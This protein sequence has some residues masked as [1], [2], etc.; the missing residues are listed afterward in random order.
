MTSDTPKQVERLTDSDIQMSYRLFLDRQPSETELTRMKA[1][2]SSIESLRK[3]FLTSSEF[4]HHYAPYAPKQKT[5]PGVHGDAQRTA[6][7]RAPTPKKLMPKLRPADMDRV[8]FLHVPKC[9][10]TSLHDILGDWYGPQNVHPERFNELYSYTGAQLATAQVFSGH[11]D[12]YATTLIPGS[13]KMISF[14]RDP[15]AR[16][17][18][19]YNFH[20]AHTPQIIARNNLLL[21]RWANELDIDDYFAEDKIRTHPAINNMIVRAF[22]NIPQTSPSIIGPK[23]TEVSLDVMLEQALENLEKFA[24]V[25]FMDTYD[26]DVNRLAQVLG[27][28]PLTDTP[29]Q[30][31][32][33]T[34]MDAG[35]NDMQK[36]QKQQ[37]SAECRDRIEEIIQYD[38]IFYTRARALLA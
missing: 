28:P 32:L 13:K 21:P 12:Y 1:A 9:G 22:S 16:L 19:L 35:D 36:I 30:Q 7:E 33:D 23:L 37:P 2:H 38:R 15:S 5:A 34:L 3:V 27:F 17:V 31:V 10:G 24:F 6:I 29:K 25:G 14:L 8:V 4:A 18:S 11:Y 20:R 26:A